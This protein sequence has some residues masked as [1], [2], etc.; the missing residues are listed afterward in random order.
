MASTL[1]VDFTHIVPRGG[2]QRHAFEELCCQL[3]H[4]TIP[5]TA[6]Y[7]RLHGAGGDGGVECFADLSPTD[8]IGWQAKYVSNIASLLDQATPSLHTALE[9]HP[10][11]SRYIICFPF[12][13]TGPTRR[14]GRSSFEKLDQWRR[15]REQDALATGRQI[16]I[17][18]WSASTLRG[19]LF[20]HDR[21]GGLREFFFNRTVLSNEWF[22]RHL[23][24]V[25]VTAGPRYTSELNVQTDLYYWVA[26][27]GRTPEWSEALVNKLEV[28]RDACERLS[29]R[30]SRSSVD[31]AL[32]GWPEAVYADAQPATSEITSLLTN[33]ADLASSNDGDVYGRCVGDLDQLLDRL[34]RME[35][36]L[37]DDLE[38]E[39]GR[40]TADAPG[41]RQYMA[42]FMVSF[43]A[44]NLDDT[45]QAITQLT[46]V[47]DWLRSPACS[48]AYESGLTLTGIAGTGKTHGV[49]DAAR[50]RFNNGLLTCVVF[51]HEFRG[52]PDPWTRLAEAL[53]LPGALGRNGIVDLL[54]SA[55]EANGR[56]LL[57][58]VDAINETRPLRYWHDHLAAFAADLGRRQHVRLVVTCR[59][60]YAELC[61]PDAYD[62]PRLEHT[63]FATV[64][65]AACHA[66]FN[67]Y[68]LDAPVAPVLQPEMTNPL[69]LR[70]LC[71]T[72]QSQGLRR[73]P[74]G[75]R[76]LAPTIN[77]FL[78]EKEKR[79]S[80]EHGTTETAGIVSGSLRAVAGGI[81]EG[82][83]NVLQ[84]SEA[85][86]LILEARPRAAG[87][88]VVDWLVREDLLIE[89]GPNARAI[90]GEESTV[91]PAFERLGDFL[92]ASE[93]LD[94]A[95]DN[96]RG[97]GGDGGLLH[98]L[99]IEPGALSKNRGVLT[100]LSILI[101]E[102]HPDIELA[103]VVGDPTMREEVVQICVR[104]LPYR[105]PSTFGETSVEVVEEAL[106]TPAFSAEVT[107]AVLSIAWEPS[108]IDA[109]WLHERL[110]ACPL[111][112]RDAVWCGYLYDRFETRGVVRRL[113]EA[114]YEVALEE[115][116]DDVAERW[117]TVLCW[118]T[119]AADRRVKDE[120]T[121]AATAILT[122]RP[123]V[124][125][126]LLATFMACN[127]DEVRERV[128]LACYGALI[129]SRSAPVLCVVVGML[130]AEYSDKPERFD[131]AMIRDHIRCIVE[132][133][134]EVGGLAE[135]L[136][137]EFSMEPI[138][139]AWPLV[140]PSD[141]EVE[142]WGE[143]VHFRPDE[144]MSDFYKYS[145]NCLEPWTE[146]V[147]K[148][149]M[150]RWILQRV[151]DDL[152]YI[153]SG[154][155]DYDR[156]MLG[157]YGGG[158]S[159]P[160]W[161]ERIGK[162]YLWI[163]MYQLAS[164]LHDH[165]EK[166]EDQ[167]MPAPLRR[168]LILLEER[169]LDPTLPRRLGSGVGE[170]DRRWAMVGNTKNLRTEVDDGDWV[171]AEDDV[172]DLSEVLQ[173][174]EHGDQQWRRL[175]SYATWGRPQEGRREDGS[176]R[177][178]W[179]HLQSYFVA[180]ED[181]EVAWSRLQRRNF[182][183]RW[184][185]DGGRCPYGFVGEYPWASAFSTEPEEWYGRTSLAG[186]A[187]F[188]CEAA[189]SELVAEWEYDGTVEE[190]RGVCVPA[191][192]WFESGELWWDQ[193]D[194][195]GVIGGK[196][197]FRDPSITHGGATGL[198]ADGDELPR[199]LERL[200]MS[201][202][203]AAVGE[204]W[205]LGGRGTDVRP[206]RT[207][208]QIARL[209]ADGSLRVGERVFFEDYDRD[210]GPGG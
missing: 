194:G 175:V 184:M 177:Q 28:C 57:M 75:W 167:W 39:H 99:W 100:A 204:K 179:M 155:E 125:P 21:S 74:A 25:E 134:G 13:L 38:A 30:W 195:Y 183:G 148:T 145:M 205:I 81:A 5:G 109:L 11:L 137:A 198:L 98:A 27:L 147:E 50:T 126:R 40:G 209:E 96:V 127:D 18:P 124:V 19:L 171:A 111:A 199:R 180:A 146:G 44:A 188:D 82:V 203:W 156:Q 133:A 200:G 31:P 59:T 181:G 22:S 34:R 144:F 95:G 174:V 87:L 73:L 23:D 162:K 45:R 42:E 102:R 110:A 182:F 186:T 154:C 1:D 58:C 159:R 33:C 91:R 49:C 77:A 64:G 108:A 80:I 62:A 24:S 130:Y 202:V 157:K 136:G 143:R 76:G 178:M 123:T 51:G 26:A 29:S 210:T 131:N 20:E 88:Q 92:V 41:F 78:Q 117:C 121:R 132:L 135:G 43:P 152:G 70:L 65:R 46:N 54:D 120:A 187:G 71:K 4:R 201:L 107:D 79:F 3:A 104:A 15:Q 196:T 84:A 7:A 97:A 208:S 192:R 176:Y 141:E 101:P 197:V 60:S 93:L 113:I 172:P 151:A 185:P 114:V 66:F 161:V 90:L 165:V 55:G 139:S 158:R 138:P 115:L 122:G 16:S 47:R 2:S 10:Q 169:K 94:R 9:V 160:S 170:R 116:N 83:D 189:W 193:R 163:A 119:A 105:H 72:L 168:P 106:R 67:H 69:Y 140:L 35:A 32:P 166:R 207:F 63:G 112:Q 149:D 142:E 103:C 164:R 48:L 12:D 150:G 129:G 6:T 14:R 56:P 86:R 206:R 89:D 128:L 68:G 118:F 37:V 190:G 53:G 191:R 153:G 17:E 85:E 61:L 52:E 8:R 173:I 36:L